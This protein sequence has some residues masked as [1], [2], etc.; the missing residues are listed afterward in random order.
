MKMKAVAI[1]CLI[2]LL[3]MG[4]FSPVNAGDPEKEAREVFVK[5]VR[6]AKAGNKAEFKS[7]I[8]AKDLREME[9]E[10]FVDMMME[11]VAEEKPEQFRAEVKQDRVI[12]RKETKVDTPEEKS[13]GK[14]TVYMIREGSEWKFGKPKDE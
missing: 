11:F 1:S 9:Q 4:L 8:A 2:W 7:Y 3:S 6:A 14:T 10:G 13:T 5:L 12:F